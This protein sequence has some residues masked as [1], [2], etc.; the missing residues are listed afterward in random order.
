MMMLMMIINKN[1]NNN[2]N[3]SIK[4]VL[5]ANESILFETIHKTHISAEA[6]RP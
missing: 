6:K 5:E 3:Q 1:N 2:N 4:N